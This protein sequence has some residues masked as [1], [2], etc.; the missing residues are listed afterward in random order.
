MLGQ[1]WSSDLIKKLKMQSEKITAEDRLE[2][3]EQLEL[4]DG[5]FTDM[6]KERDDAVEKKKNLIVALMASQELNA[7]LLHAAK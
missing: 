5:A 4:L 7:A 6:L 1:K 3:A 2:I